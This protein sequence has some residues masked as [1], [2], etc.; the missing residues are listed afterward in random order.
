M[1][2][3]EDTPLDEWIWKRDAGM[4]TDEQFVAFVKSATYSELLTEQEE[5]LQSPGEEKWTV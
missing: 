2:R 3:P 1:H 5:T 4:V